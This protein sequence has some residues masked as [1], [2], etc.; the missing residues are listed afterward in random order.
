MPRDSRSER[1]H[2]GPWRMAWRQR[3][4]RASR[5]V[6]SELRDHARQM[7]AVEGFFSLPLPINAFLDL[8]LDR[9]RM[10]TS[11][12]RDPKFSPIC[13]GRGEEESRS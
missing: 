3:S 4:P 5:L 2:R 13:A 11:E 1:R 7:G 9:I 12:S 6:T 8:N 10:Y